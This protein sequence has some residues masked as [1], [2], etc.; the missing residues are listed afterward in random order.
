MNDPIR[1]LVTRGANAEEIRA[2]AIKS[3]MMTMRR[4]AM[5]KVKDGITTP[6]EVLR[7]VFTI[8]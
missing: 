7:N 3:G 1:A 4:D 2:E 6:R 8:A 5:L